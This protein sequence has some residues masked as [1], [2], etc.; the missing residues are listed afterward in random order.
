MPRRKRPNPQS[1]ENIRRIDTKARAKKQTHGF[2]VHFLRGDRVVTKM[3]SDN[4][5]GGKPAARRAARKNSNS[6]CCVVCRGESFWA[7]KLFATRLHLLLPVGFPAF[8]I[9]QNP[10]VRGCP[11]ID[12]RRRKK[13]ACSDFTLVW[14]N[15][16]GSLAA[17][18]PDKLMVGARRCRELGNSFERNRN[19]Q[20]LFQFTPRCFIISFSARLH[21]RQRLSPISTDV[22]PSNASA[23]ANKLHR[24]H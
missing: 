19:A 20:F 5:Y 9:G 24:P 8:R 7:N 12:H 3:F 18:Q 23:A 14:G 2:Q 22:Y 13:Y 4:V 21:G 15:I 6:R 1:E 10:R 16:F 17:I 11:A